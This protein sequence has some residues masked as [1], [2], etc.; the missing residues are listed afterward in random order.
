VTEGKFPE[1][2]TSLPEVI[3]PLEGVKGW[4]AQGK[5]FQIVFFEIKPGSVPPHSHSAQWGIVIEGE[6]SLTIGE[7]TKK[8]HKGDSYYIPEGV[9]HQAEIHTNFRAL[10]FFAEPER[11]KTK[12]E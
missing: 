10:D 4:T 5:D 12:E 1:I 6:M 3:V 8:Y 11:Y 2:I 7:E 9:I